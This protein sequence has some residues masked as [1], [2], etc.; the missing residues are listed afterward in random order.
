MLCMAVNSIFAAVSTPHR[1]G[2]LLKSFL[3]NE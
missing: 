1:Q 2:D 3:S